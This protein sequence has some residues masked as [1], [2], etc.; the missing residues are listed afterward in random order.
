MLLENNGRM[1]SGKSTNHIKSIYFLIADN[2]EK[3]KL[4]IQH[5]LTEQMW[6]DGLNNLK[7]GKAF[8]FFTVI[9]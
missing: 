9:W 4:E 7:Q 2:I 8:K 6:A 1:T 3:R 5:F